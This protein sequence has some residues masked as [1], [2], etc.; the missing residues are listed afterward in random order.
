MC[1][2]LTLAAGSIFFAY[3]RPCSAVIAGTIVRSMTSSHSAIALIVEATSS[4]SLIT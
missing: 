1:S 3:S 2:W 4:A